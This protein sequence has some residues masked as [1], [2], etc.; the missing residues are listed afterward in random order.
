[1]ARKARKNYYSEFFHIMVQGLNKEFV[2]NTN[3]DINKYLEILKKN[4]DEDYNYVKLIAYCVMNNH[5]HMLF[6]T[7]NTEFI[8]KIMQKTNTKYALFYNKKYDRCGYVFRNRYR[9]EEIIDATYLINCI[10]YIHNNPV[11]AGICNKK[12]DYLY[13]S[14]LE[15]QGKSRYNVIDI[16]YIKNLFEYFGIDFEKIFSDVECIAKFIE[17]YDNNKNI[18]EIVNDYI[19]DKNIG[20]MEL[21]NNMKLFREVIEILCYDYGF[22]QNEIANFFNVSNSKVCKMI[23]GKLNKVKI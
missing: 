10:R 3:E 23:N 17:Y 2:F 15:Y 4:C 8:S 7:Q 1:M 20:V 12:D 14:F 19:K 22:K 9:A 5:I 16:K 11:K 18:D 6:Y 21:K 13:S